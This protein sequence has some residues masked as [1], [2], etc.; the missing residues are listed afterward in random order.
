MPVIEPTIDDYERADI[1][2]HIARLLRDLG[3][4][5]PPLRLE[6][7]RELQ[8]LDLTYYSKSDINLLDEMAHKAKMAGHKISST[9]KSMR[10]IVTEFSLKGL[11]MLREGDKR[12]FIDDDD[13]PLKR[14]F[15]IAH[16]S[17]MTCCPGIA[18][19]SSGTTSRRSI[20]PFTRRWKPRQTTVVVASFS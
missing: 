18:L 19:C 7:V 16:E 1:N 15:V 6:I 17:Y 2:E 11:L 4:P 8:Q 14:R 12:I 20:Q 3:N 9:A 5:E 13:V 10:D